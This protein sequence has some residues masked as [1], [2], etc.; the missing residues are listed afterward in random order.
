MNIFLDEKY[1][2]WA[3]L[4]IND[5]ASISVCGFA[6]YNNV[7]YSNKDLS[8]YLKDKLN[9]CGKGKEIQILKNIICNLNG[10]WSLVYRNNDK[11]FAVV[12]RL[13]SIPLFY[14]SQDNLFYLSN[15][16]Y[17]LKRKI[18]QA[19]INLSSEREFLTTRYVANRDTLF[20]SI[21]QIKSGEYLI[22]FRKN[23]KINIKRGEYF[24][25]LYKKFFRESEKNIYK[26]L[27]K[28]SDRVFRRLILSVKKSSII[29]PLSGGYDSRY[30]VTML[31]QLGYEKVI[32]FSYGRKRNKESAISKKVADRLGYKWLF[33]EY[34]PKMW[35]DWFNSKERK[36]YQKF[37]ENLSSVM[38]VQDFLAVKELKEK[39]LIPKNS[40][41]VP[42]HS[43]DML[44][45]SQIPR[46][47]NFKK[48]YMLKEVMDYLFRM[49]ECLNRKD[50][51]ERFN[52][53]K[54]SLFKIYGKKLT[55]KEYASLIEFFIFSNKV[56]KFV[57]NSVRVYDFY[58]Y[59]WR[60]PLW[61]NELVDFW[62]KIP[63][64]SRKGSKLYN[65]YLLKLFANYGVDFQKKPKSSY[66]FF[67]IK[68][69][70][71]NI[72]PKTI[73]HKF[74]LS[75]D[76]TEVLKGLMLFFK[77]NNLG[78][79]RML[80]KKPNYYIANLQIQNLKNGFFS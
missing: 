63:L 71:K 76:K 45:G 15:N 49:G 28:V 31:K 17:L 7:F 52:R 38:H 55:S 16:A 62:L 19:R 37:A 75:Q 41:F 59:Q 54:E 73:L 79:D 29:V 35:L 20:K 40:V 42:G 30:I 36:D 39:K 23:N 60:I 13:R 10:S 43:G 46:G 33:V 67:Q 61:D 48:N 77:E 32:C 53:L 4:K 11:V 70:I 1:I 58:N 2:D 25:Y 64:K 3:S 78:V 24:Q 57:V 72:S 34:K 8:R 44:G 27:D 69:I 6:F 51:E 56:S 22:G 65:R 47:I 26:E 74:R 66:L 18:G 9:D 5:R 14:I 80:G 68:Q 50:N 12:D 21:K